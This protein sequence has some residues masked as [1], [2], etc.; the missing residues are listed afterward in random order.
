MLLLTLVESVVLVGCVLPL[1]VVGFLRLLVVS[2]RVGAKLVR[3]SSWSLV[4]DTSRCVSCWG[5]RPNWLSNC[6][7]WSVLGAWCLVLGAWCWCCADVRAAILDVVQADVH[8]EV[9][10]VRD[11]LDA[12]QVV[13]DIPPDYPL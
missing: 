3:N 11:V 13:H 9:L 1:L 10:A 2:V 8:A 7:G 5:C 4:V 12:V 6:C